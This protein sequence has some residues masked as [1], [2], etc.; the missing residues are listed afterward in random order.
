MKIPQCIKLSLSFLFLV[1]LFYSHLAHSQGN[2]NNQKYFNWHDAM[3]A[4]GNAY[5]TADADLEKCSEGVLDDQGR[6]PKEKAVSHQN[7]INRII[8]KRVLPYAMFPDLVVKL[9]GEILRIAQDYQDG[10]IEREEANQKS[11]KAKADFWEAT[12]K[13]SFHAR[14]AE[15]N[16]ECAALYYN[17]ANG[18]K[19]KSPLW[20]EEIARAASKAVVT[21]IAHVRFA[22]ESE[23]GTAYFQSEIFESDLNNRVDKR[24]EYWDSQREMESSSFVEQMNAC[25]ELLPEQDKLNKILD[26]LRRRIFKS[27]NSSMTTKRNL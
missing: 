25:K 23:Q 20:A 17:L 16:L 15:Q 24:Q 10:K 13:R 4:E 18:I 26:D 8:G 12:E 11:D 19:Q 7:C 21:I 27:S 5:R 1:N 2:P 14:M 6:I 9:H 3:Q 22:Y